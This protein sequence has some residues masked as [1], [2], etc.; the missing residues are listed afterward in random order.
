MGNAVIVASMAGTF[1]VLALLGIPIVFAIIASVVLATIVTGVGPTA[2]ANELFSGINSNTL[3]AVPFF[4]LVGEI[5][6]SAGVAS[7]IIRLAQAL[8]GHIKSGLAHVVVVFS[9]FFSG[10]SGSSNADAA[11]MSRTIMPSMQKE[12]YNPGSSAAIVA[13]ASTIANMIPPSI[14]AIVY[15]ATGGVSVAALF[16]GGVV[17]GVLVGLGLMLYSHFFGF[18]VSTRKRADA[19][20]L[21]WAV[22]GSLLP[23]VVPFV[24]LGGIFLGWFTPTEA[25]MAAVV[26]IV[27]VL[28]PLSA[29]GHFRR[30]PRDFNEAGVLYTLPLMAVAAASAFAYIIAYLNG[31]QIVSAWVQGVAGT[32]PVP[33]MFLLVAILVIAGQFLDAVPAIVIFMPI[34]GELVDLGGINPIHMGVVVIVT[35]AFGLITPPYGLSLLLSTYFAGISFRQG[36]V[37]ALPIYGVFSVVIAVLVLFPDLSLSL[38][39]LLVPRAAGCFPASG[40]EG[41]VCP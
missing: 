15:G 24:I 23:L 8:V 18:P 2:M 40:G 17:P 14:M 3:L 16:L 41:L 30:L 10:I 25:G 13:A 37:K 39:R 1:L 36:M 35:L 38:P 28:I 4:M 6:T 20:E 11:A 12:G 27:A 33:I 5:L 22:R 29:R 32:N 31:P 34:I 26:Y 9:M 7:K 19:N 21:A